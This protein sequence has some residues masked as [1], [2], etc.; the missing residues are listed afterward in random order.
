MGRP[1]KIDRLP[2]EVREAIARLREAGHTLDEIL[3]HLGKMGL[4]AEG[5]PSRSGLHRHVQ[6]LDEVAENLMRDRTMAD[7]LVRRLGDAP[8]G[9]MASLNVQMMQGIVFQAL[10]AARAEG[11]VAL[12]PRETAF[13]ARSL[14]QLA[15][16][17]RADADLTLRLRK[18]AQAE[19]ERRVRQVEEE[20]TGAAMTPL[21]ALERVR[22]LYRGEG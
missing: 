14:A 22:A 12:D 20:A 17:N 9:R 15:Q 4:D 13:L 18:E 16:A 2:A 10:Q 3:V 1:S 19:M 7:A 5:M 11:G 6:G 21:Q 8:E